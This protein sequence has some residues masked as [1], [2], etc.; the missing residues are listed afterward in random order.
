[1]CDVWKTWKCISGTKWL[2]NWK[3]IRNVLITFKKLLLD[4]LVSPL[5]S[6]S[7]RQDEDGI[8]EVELKIE[9]EK[10]VLKEPPSILESTDLIRGLP[11][12]L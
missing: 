9:E 12:D 10:E 3:C 2:R 5:K 6:V 1:M 4:G 7:Y 11:I 8:T